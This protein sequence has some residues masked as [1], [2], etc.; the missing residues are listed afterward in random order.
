[1]KKE[2][3]VGTVIQD[4][5][6]SKDDHPRRWNRSQRAQLFDQSLDLH[7]QGLSLRQ[8]AKAL[9][10]PRSTLQAWRADHESLDEHPAVVAFFHSSPGLAFLHRL[11]LAMHL[12]CPEVGACGIHLVCLLLKLTALDCVFHGI[13]PP[14]PQESCHPIH[15]KAAT[16]STGKLPLSPWESC[17]PIHGKA[18][19]PSRTKQPWTIGAQRR[20]RVSG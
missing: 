13:L 14:N 11:V 6:R 19:I 12:V 3:A 1:M 20:T 10:V 18:A 17:H 4:A 7:A 16:E 2:V 8:A 15:G 5:Q 9:E